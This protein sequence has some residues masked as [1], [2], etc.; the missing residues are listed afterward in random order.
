MLPVKLAF[1]LNGGLSAGYVKADRA[2]HLHELVGSDVE[3]E[4]LPV[5]VAH[6]GYVVL[7]C[8]NMEPFAEAPADR[9]SLQGLSPQGRDDG[10]EAARYPQILDRS[11]PPEV[12]GEVG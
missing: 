4:V 9:V 8:S 7:L 6:N 12:V 3:P 2:E 5:L 11:G 1:R 10:N